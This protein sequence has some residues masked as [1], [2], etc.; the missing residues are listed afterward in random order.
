MILLCPY[1]VPDRKDRQETRVSTSVETQ[2]LS[3]LD[4]I[5]I[6]NAKRNRCGVHAMAVVS[7][8]LP[9]AMP[10]IVLTLMI[11]MLLGCQGTD[12]RNPKDRRDAVGSHEKPKFKNAFGNERCSKNV[13]GN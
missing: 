7:I 12:C 3:S 9:I 11:P 4:G 1:T 13:D 5:P 8:A 6:N 2:S 10:V